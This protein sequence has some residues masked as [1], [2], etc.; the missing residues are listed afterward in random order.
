MGDA[1][2]QN[3]TNGISPDDFLQQAFAPLHPL[4]IEEHAID[5]VPSIKAI[6]VGSGITGIT[7]AILL[8]RKVPGLELTI[9]ERNP[10][11]VSCNSRLD[12]QSRKRMLT[13]RIGRSVV[14]KYISRSSM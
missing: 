1:G 13:G 9:Y 2:L 7:A 14:C 8:P 6:L 4:T 12:I 3:G 5:D 11:V 10:E